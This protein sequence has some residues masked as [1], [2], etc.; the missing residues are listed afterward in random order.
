VWSVNPCCFDLAA[1]PGPSWLFERLPG[2]VRRTDRRS[3]SCRLS[4]TSERDPL[5]ASQ[6]NADH[7]S[8]EANLLVAKDLSIR[9][10]RAFDF[11]LFRW[12]RRVALGLCPS[13]NKN[14]N[15]GHWCVTRIMNW[16][17]AVSEDSRLNHGEFDSGTLKLLR[18]MCMETYGRSCRGLFM[19]SGRLCVDFTSYTA[20]GAGLFSH[21]LVA[22]FVKPYSIKTGAAAHGSVFRL[23]QVG[24]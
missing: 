6:S 2:R 23:P 1:N 22:G 17:L 4:R 19:N 7:I 21:Q 11:E 10:A 15:R 20:G 8:R 24:G 9:I 5:S 18:C 3:F 14:K 12:R 13:C 16:P